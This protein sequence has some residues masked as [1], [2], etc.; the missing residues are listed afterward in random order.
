MTEINWN[1]VWKNQLEAHINSRGQGE[2]ALMWDTKEK[3]EKYLRMVDQNPERV[4]KILSQLSI[5]PHFRVLDIGA[6]PGTLSVPL[7]G[8]VH[9]VTAVEPAFGMAELLKERSQKETIGNI[10]IVQKRWEDINIQKDLTPPYD[11]VIASYSLVMPDLK[12][13]IET[14]QKVCCGEIWLFW[15]AGSNSWENHM[16]KLWPVIHGKP[17]TS[18]P[19]VDALFNVLYQMNVYPNVSFTE[20]GHVKSFSSIEEAVEETRKNLNCSADFDNQ[21]RELLLP[22]L[23][24]QNGMYINQERYN[25]ACFSWKNEV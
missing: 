8:K 11:L 19:K 23:V 22:N 13:A 20:M 3:A 7:S 14:M 24:F 9:H 16:R 15:M 21:I 25:S 10:D 5:F 6:G 4:E 2:Y 18:P 17:F 12:Q 1:A